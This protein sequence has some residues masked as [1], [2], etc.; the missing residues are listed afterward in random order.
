MLFLLY[1]LIDYKLG[2]IIYEVTTCITRIDATIWFDE[3]ISYV[4]DGLRI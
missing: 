1:S 2:L 4:P 3:I